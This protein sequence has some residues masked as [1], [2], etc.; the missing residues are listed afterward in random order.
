MTRIKGRSPAPT[1]TIRQSTTPAF[2]ISAMTKDRSSSGTLAITATNATRRSALGRCPVA[3]RVGMGAPRETAPGRR[4]EAER[5]APALPH[6][7]HPP[8]PAGRMGP[9]VRGHGLSAEWRR[10]QRQDGSVQ[11]LQLLLPRLRDLE[12]ESPALVG[13]QEVPQLSPADH[14]PVDEERCDCVNL[15]WPLCDALIWPHPLSGV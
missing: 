8:A 5:G 14:V 9:R 12:A 2:R 13:V 7:A 11:G 15:I 3:R 6:P 4:E 10:A 1:S